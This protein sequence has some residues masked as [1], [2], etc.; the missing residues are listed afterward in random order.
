MVN[1]L[2]IISLSKTYGKGSSLVRALDSVSL[3]IPEGKVA[4]LMGPSGSGKS[5]LL[6]VVGALLKPDGGTVFLDGT[7]ITQIHSNARSSYRREKIGFVFQAN[8]LIP[9]LTAAENIHLPLEIGFRGVGCSS[10]A[11]QELI[12][13]FGLASRANALA[14]D[15]SGGERQR[16]AIARALIRDPKILLVDEPTANLDSTAG[17]QIVDALIREVHQQKKI[18]IMVTHDIAMANRCDF[19]VGIR[20]GCIVSSL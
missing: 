5:T 15:L 6:A 10:R 13:E 9:Y 19:V 8:N 18:G 12:E 1:G 11:T 14:S 3:N 2:E 20:D 17:G 16:V 7:E 4:A